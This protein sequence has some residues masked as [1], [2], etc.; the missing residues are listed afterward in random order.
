MVSR[1]SFTNRV[2]MR[3]VSLLADV[4][5]VPQAY[6]RW[7]SLLYHY[8]ETYTGTTNSTTSSAFGG[9]VPWTLIVKPETEEQQCSSYRNL[10]DEVLL[11]LNKLGK[12]MKG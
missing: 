2:K 12:T 8:P 9:S 3:P 10:T 7:W 6:Q 11:S 4:L 1:R 5:A